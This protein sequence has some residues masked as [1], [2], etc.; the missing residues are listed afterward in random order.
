MGFEKPEL[1]FKDRECLAGDQY[2]ALI[3]YKPHQITQL[4][5]FSHFNTRSPCGKMYKVVFP[6]TSPSQISHMATPLVLNASWQPRPYLAGAE[7]QV[8]GA[9]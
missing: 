6:G 3:V 8:L 1:W 2:S 7:S 4:K 9:I 5:I